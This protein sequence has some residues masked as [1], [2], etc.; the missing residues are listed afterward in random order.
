MWSRELG[1]LTPA[2]Q[3]ETAKLQE[4]ISAVLEPFYAEAIAKGV[5]R[6]LDPRIVRRLV[7]GTTFNLTRW[8]ERLSDLPMETIVEQVIDTRTSGLLLND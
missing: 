7:F 5:I 1:H 4:R 6:P 3:K 8:T 2:H